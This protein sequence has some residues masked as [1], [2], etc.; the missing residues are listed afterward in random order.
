MRQQGAARPDQP[1]P[2]SGAGGARV[3]AGQRGHQVLRLAATRRVLPA[4][5]RLPAHPPHALRRPELQPHQDC[6]EQRHQP[7]RR[8]KLLEA[9]GTKVVRACVGTG[10][11]RKHA[12]RSWLKFAQNQ[13]TKLL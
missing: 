12:D 1:H 7:H 3:L 11:Y 10:R 9:Q 4:Q 13:S 8:R 2:G 5:R 6:A